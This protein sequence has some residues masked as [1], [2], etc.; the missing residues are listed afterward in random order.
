MLWGID[1]G[2]TKIECAV[3]SGMGNP[4][5]VVR[6]RIPSGADQ[7]YENALNQIK[8]IVDHASDKLGVKPEK[9]GIGT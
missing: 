2:G 8:K 1:L 5:V 4:E 6:D 3:M 9:I 7:G